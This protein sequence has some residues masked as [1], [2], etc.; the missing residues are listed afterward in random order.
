MLGA[1]EHLQAQQRSFDDLGTPLADVTF[2]VLDIETTGSDRDADLI[3]ELGMVKVRAGEFLGTFQTL[4]NPGR[5]IPPMITVLTGITEAMVSRAP[6]IDAVLPSMLE[7][8]RNTVLVGHN[9][10]FDM[11]FI[12]AALSR[13][14]DESLANMVIDTL[15]LAR[16]LVRDEVPDCRL[17]T[18][19]SRFRLDHRP[20]HR[21]LDDA[22]ATTDLLHLLLERAAGL[23]VLG[24]DDLV[25]LPRIG[26]HP[27]AA[28]LRM[29]SSLPRAPGVYMFRGGG[30]HVIYVGKATNLR[31]RVRSYFGGDDRRKIGPLLRETQR[32]THAVTPNVL[33]AEVLELRYLQQLAPRY[34]RVGTTPQKYRY[35]RL[36]VDEP[37]PRLSV[38]TDPSSTGVHL[39][40]LPSKATAD[41]VVEALHSVLPLRRC[42]ARLS[43]QFQ[44]L[45]G[46]SP[47]TPAQL[48]VAMCPCSGD[49]DARRY[50][51]AVHAAA[52]ALTTSPEHIVA[53][54][55]TRLA[56]LSAERRYE[57]AAQ[58]R[59]RAM[60]FT[61]A[62]RRLRLADALRRAGDVGLRLGEIT[63]HIRDG[64]LVGT[65]AEGQMEIGLDV[66][67]P[68]V[69]PPGQPLSR[70][71]ID[72][73]LCLARNVER[74]GPALEV[75]WC[76]GTWQWP[77]AAV[78]EV[79][80]RPLPD[81][82]QRAA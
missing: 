74:L 23:G 62:H 53:S 29:T 73:V 63:V 44:A 20:T 82:A 41:L 42:T 75:V 13:R 14:G 69:P 77:V 27:Q 51:E 36:A 72:E 7:F 33:A 30:D 26:A 3:T 40:P 16:R 67:P 37:W 80:G 28:K 61:N 60:A 43:R 70:G 35:V 71:A 47:C 22:L 39:G 64:V 79:V 81:D 55:Q 12:N 32:I 49:A 10:G 59:D 57:E 68:A 38:V 54:L 76:S 19:A 24:L 5:A 66:P 31:Q 48:G 45:A 56:A 78:P 52:Q 2:C 25:N 50:D 6:A 17:H 46:A 8:V 1:G 11:A 9:V 58:V 18:L 4:V 65:A 21:A 34:N 15:P